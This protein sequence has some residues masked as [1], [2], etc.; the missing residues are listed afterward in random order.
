M[1]DDVDGN[2]ISEEQTPKYTGKRKCLAACRDQ[3]WR[4]KWFKQGLY[5]DSN[6]GWPKSRKLRYGP[7]GYHQ[8]FKFLNVMYI[9][10]SCYN[11][12]HFEENQIA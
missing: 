9:T 11:A 10:Q 1:T 12:I 4:L 8:K 7:A 3:G 6:E 2:R 5:I